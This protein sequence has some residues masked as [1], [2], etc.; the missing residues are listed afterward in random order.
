MYT[1]SASSV[2]SI[3][4]LFDR[5]YWTCETFEDVC[6]CVCV[7]LCPVFVEVMLMLLGPLRKTSDIAF[8]LS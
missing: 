6:V 1:S 8:Q 4:Q 3:V 5:Q 7:C 2:L